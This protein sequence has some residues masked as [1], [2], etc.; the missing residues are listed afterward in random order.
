[1]PDDG[2]TT[3]DSNPSHFT[4]M[5]RDAPKNWGRWGEDDEL[6]ALNF[7]TSD[8]VIRAAGE[9]KRGAVFTLGA[10]IGGPEGEPVWPGRVEAQRYNARDRASYSCGRIEPF[11]GGLEYADDMIVMWLQGTTHFDALGHA[12]YEDK[13]W[14]GYSADETVDH[15]SKASVYPIAKRGIVGRAV[16]IDLARFKGKDALDAGEAF[17][18][19]DILAAAEHQGSPIEPHDILLIRTGWLRRFYEDRRAFYSEPFV[20]PG[21]V[22]A[23]EVATWFHEREI[24][25]YATDTVGNELTHQPGSGVMAALHASLMRN[26]GVLFSEILW[27]E[28]IADDCAEDGR[29]TFMFVAGPLK[30]VGGTGAPVNPVAIK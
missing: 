22:Y 23:P 15:I 25:A 27:L 16:L 17:T 1:M 7:L 8:E 28:D 29:W 5:L 3:A 24:V 26:L 11:P 9:I 2:V 18:L 30:I 13:I 6:G 20:E 10:S 14:N 4:E 21:L 19:S 12:W